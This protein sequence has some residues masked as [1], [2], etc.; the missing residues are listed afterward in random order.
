MHRQYKS[1]LALCWLIPE[2]WSKSIDLHN[3]E[4][5]SY[6]HQ[7][8]DSIYLFLAVLTNFQLN[9]IANNARGDDI[10]HLKGIVIDWISGAEP[11]QP[12]LSKQDRSG[13]WLH[14]NVTARLLC[15]ITYAWDDPECQG[16]STPTLSACYDLFGGC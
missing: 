14:H 16:H 2:F 3:N 1:Y 11:L 4:I 12:P 15:P 6:Y 8:G 13:R 10:H 9:T 5:L 7:A